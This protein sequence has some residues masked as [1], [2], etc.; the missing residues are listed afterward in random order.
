MLQGLINNRRLVQTI[1]TFIL[2]TRKYEGKKIKRN[3]NLKKKTF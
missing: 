1:K 3:K 2:L